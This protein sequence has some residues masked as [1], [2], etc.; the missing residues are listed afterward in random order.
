EAVGHYRSL[1]PSTGGWYEPISSTAV[2]VRQSA[3]RDV[4][5]RVRMRVGESAAGPGAGARPGGR[6]RHGKGTRVVHR[7]DAT[8]CRWA[9][10]KSRDAQRGGTRTRWRHTDLRS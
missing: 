8:A 2:G 1:R 5:A 9:A 4:R 6:P 3:G 10:E 7:G